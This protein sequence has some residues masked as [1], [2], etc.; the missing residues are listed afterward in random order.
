M[1][2]WYP[3]GPWVCSGPAPPTP[4]RFHDRH[5]S[6]RLTHTPYTADCADSQAGHL[7]SLEPQ[8]LKMLRNGFSPLPTP[9]PQT[10]GARLICI[11]RSKILTEMRKN[12]KA[13]PKNCTIRFVSDLLRPALAMWDPVLQK[14]WTQIKGFVSLGLKTFHHFF[15][16][17]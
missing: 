14:I 4:A 15:L 3:L 5:L 2:A 12:T 1:V 7:L 10:P 9:P 11:L 13:K 8:I 17:A 6:T 16:L